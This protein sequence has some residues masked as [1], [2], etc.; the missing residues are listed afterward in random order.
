M[1]PTNR[2]YYSDAYRTAFSSDVADRSDDGTRVYLVETA[3]YP[4]SG[5]QLNDLGTLGGVAVSDVVDEGDRIAHVL[6]ESL[7]SG[8][9]RVDEGRPQRVCRAPCL[10]SRP[11]P[12]R[13][14]RAL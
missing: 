8:A 10:A 9:R 4:T 12:R 6:A 14:W 11:T 5:G 2:L 1:S 7:P 13:S 3:F